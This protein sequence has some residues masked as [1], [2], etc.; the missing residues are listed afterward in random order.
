MLTIVDFN[1]NNLVATPPADT[2]LLAAP[3]VGAQFKVQV[4]VEEND[5]TLPSAYVNGTL[6]WHDGS[7][8]VVYSGTGTVTINTFKFL[9]PGNYFISVLGQNF[10]A[11]MP[12]QT[13]V[14]Y[15]VKVV[16]TGQQVPPANI[17]IGP[18]LP[19]DKG[20]PNV[21]N[22]NFNTSTDINILES[23][24]KML[25][26]TAKGERVMLPNYGTNLRQIIF[27]QNV[28]GIESLVQQEI[29]DAITTWE[30]RVQLMGIEVKRNADKSVVVQ[31]TFLSKLDQTGFTTSLTYQ[32]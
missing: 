13:E 18:I 5:P 14:N 29:V 23:S 31:A 3:N 32:P 15:F 30:P 28:Q 8:P 11:P 21:D 24:L 16:P 17:L 10:R 20:F 1:G 26:L 22:W 12:D 7:P 25:L 19:K 27:Q 6:N 9:F 4:L 2:T